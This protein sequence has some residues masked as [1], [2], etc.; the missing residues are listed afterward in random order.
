MIEIIT[1]SS[2]DTNPKKIIILCPTSNKETSKYPI[3]RVARHA[4]NLNIQEWY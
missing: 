1:A 2:T 4:S 3:I